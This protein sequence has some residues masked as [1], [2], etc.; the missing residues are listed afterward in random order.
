[1][2]DTYLIY[3][4][5]V[6]NVDFNTKKNSSNICTDKDIEETDFSSDCGL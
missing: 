1:M 2:M 6:K 4:L 5:K 3:I